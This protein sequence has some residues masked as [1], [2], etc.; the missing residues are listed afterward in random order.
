VTDAGKL[1]TI[2]Y[3]VTGI[4]IPLAFVT[5]VAGEVRRDQRARAD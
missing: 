1:F 3:L 2:A 5:E 4:G